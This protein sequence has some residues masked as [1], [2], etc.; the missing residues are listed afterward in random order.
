MSDAD[1]KDVPQGN[2]DG[3]TAGINDLPDPAS[4]VAPEGGGPKK[5]K[6]R[7]LP[8]ESGLSI[9]SLMDILT[10]ILVFL[11]KSYSTNPIQ[12][13]SADN[14]KLP[15]SSSQ[16]IPTMSTAVTVTLDNVMVGD[17]PAVSLD[18]GKV[19]E[20]DL[21]SGSFL[22]EPVYQALQ[23][24][25]DKQRRIAKFNKSAEFS[26]I[27]TIIADRHVP[28]QLLSQVMYTAGQA[29]FSKF[30]FAVIKRG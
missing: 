20:Q 16:V 13:K 27:I 24:E 29:E 23:E 7:A 30:K 19:S 11:I 2:D 1:I 12:P 14:L 28:F 25:V 8:E 9:T 4:F 17:K 3:V 6:R 18:A 15:F 5:R 21:S 26:G 22:I 10:I